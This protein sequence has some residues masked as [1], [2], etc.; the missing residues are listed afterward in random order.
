MGVFGQEPGSGVLPVRDPQGRVRAT[1]P[2]TFP[3]VTVAVT[4]VGVGVT[5]GQVTAVIAVTAPGSDRLA[6]VGSLRGVVL[7]AT[8][9]GAFGP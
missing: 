1:A 3:A 5:G 8:P 7:A 9:G 4:G 6:V 2:P